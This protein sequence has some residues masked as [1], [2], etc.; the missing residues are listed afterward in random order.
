LIEIDTEHRVLAAPRTQRFII[1]RNRE[2]PRF[3]R[4]FAARYWWDGGTQEAC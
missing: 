1:A 3:G 4:D 2:N